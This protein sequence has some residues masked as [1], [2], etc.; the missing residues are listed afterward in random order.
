MRLSGTVMTAIGPLA[1]R[2]EIEGDRIVGLEPDAA[3]G[4]DL[5]LPG[6]VDL[7]C[8]GGGGRDVMD[9]E[10]A[11]A[12]IAAH[13]ARGGTTSL[14]ATTLTA[15]PERLRAALDG[16]AA[17]MAR[18]EDSAARI[19]GVHLEGPFIS[20]AMLGA[21][22]PYARETE[23]GL[24][25]D[26]CARAPVRVITFAPEADPDGRLLAFAGARGIRAQ[27]GH[28]PCRYE[29][30]A[31]AFARGASGVTHL[32]NAMSG[33]HH[34]APGLTGAALAHA[35]Y[36]ELIPDLL[37]VHPGAILAAI[38]AIPGLY[39]VTDATRAA[40][41]PDGTYPFGDGTAEKCQNGLRLPDGT[42]AGSCLTMLEAFRNLVAVGLSPAEAA[43]RCATLP[44]EYLALS[45]RG[46]L[47]AGAVADLIVL[48]PDLSLKEVVLRGRRVHG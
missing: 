45:D 27:L 46:R 40:G 25:E 28:S 29:D 39:A 47:G 15:P 1:G 19:L 23:I 30:A 44:A 10:G 43:R 21:Q 6:F 36:A 5:L 22:P 9:A 34:R 14:L 38:R 48:G 13:H 35:P 7:H 31:Q 24:L 11:A 4:G 2:I 41:M 18:P 17:A 16:V 3:A 37:H 20:P 12:G 42:L 33:L 8:H 32:F 26:L